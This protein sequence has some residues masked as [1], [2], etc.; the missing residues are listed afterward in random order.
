[1]EAGDKFDVKV[2]LGST[3]ESVVEMTGFQDASEAARARDIL[4]IKHT[5]MSS[6]SLNFPESMYASDVHNIQKMEPTELK[7]RL[8]LGLPMDSKSINAETSQNKGSKR[9]DRWECAFSPHS[10]Y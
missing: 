7:K 9:S 6:W 3:G 4:V 5:P 2:Q 8:K 1:M 10:M